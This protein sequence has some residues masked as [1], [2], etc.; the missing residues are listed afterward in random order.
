MAAKRKRKHKGAKGVVR[1]L[2]KAKKKG[3]KRGKKK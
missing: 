1:K 2:K 3:K